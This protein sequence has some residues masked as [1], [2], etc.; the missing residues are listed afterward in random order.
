MAFQD[1]VELTTG[2]APLRLS[3]FHVEFGVELTRSAPSGL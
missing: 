3:H 1:A 2:G